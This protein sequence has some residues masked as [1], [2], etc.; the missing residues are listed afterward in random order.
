[1]ELRAIQTFTTIV[2]AGSFQKAAK[3]LNYSQ[4]TISMRIKQLEQDLGVQ[5][6]ER[7]KSLKLTKAG[8]IFYERSKQ[9]LIQYEVLDHTIFDLRAGNTGEIKIGISEPT[10][11][12]VLPHVLTPFL[13]EYPNLN[14]TILVEDA[15]TCSKKLVKGEI[16]F[17]ICGEPELI[18]ENYYKVFYRD[19]LDILVAKKN[20][21]ASKESV[22]LADLKEE[23]FIFTPANCPI[24][25][26]IEQELKQAIGSTYKKL[27]V[28]S[29]MAHKH[30]VAQDL[31]ISIFTKIAHLNTVPGTKAIPVEDLD[32]HPPIG[33]LTNQKKESFDM[34]TE[35]LLERITAFFQA[36][37]EL[38][39]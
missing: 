15:N 1:M 14:I 7:G 27:E 33:I 34:M 18:L 8:N 38:S 11:S 32:I 23:R 9:L 29:S 6:F 19:S 21:L 36:K 4:P 35:E 2:Q 3:I 10:A 39:L 25:I 12:L 28:S 37:T 16:D 17:A 20:P 13:E 5:L 30:Y 24:R 31:G 26:Q 22:T